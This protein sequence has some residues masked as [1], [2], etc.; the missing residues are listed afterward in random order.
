MKKQAM[1]CGQ[2]MMFESQLII[3]QPKQVAPSASHTRADH[4]HTG[5]SSNPINH[6]HLWERVGIIAQTVVGWCWG[7]I[8]CCRRAQEA[9][10][11]QVYGDICQFCFFCF[12]PWRY[13]QKEKCLFICIYFV[14]CLFDIPHVSSLLMREEE[15]LNL[16]FKFGLFKE[17]SSCHGNSMILYYS[18]IRYT[19][20]K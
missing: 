19:L 16:S 20:N 18:S 13:E 7:G 5:G 6:I 8:H 3:T 17:I 11:H 9:D 15:V 1:F 12:F 2:D 10:K 4:E 14:N